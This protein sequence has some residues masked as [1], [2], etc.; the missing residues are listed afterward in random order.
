MKSF[1]VAIAGAGVFGAWTAFFLA[2]AGAKVILIDPHGAGNA[3]SSSGGETRIMRMTYGADE[4]YTRSAIRS[5]AL[6]KQ[7]FPSVFRKTGVLVTSS[8][9]DPYLHGTRETLAR[10]KYRFEWLD[11]AALASRFPSISLQPGSAGIFEPSS[12]VLMARHAVQQVVAAAVDAGARFEIGCVRPDAL[13]KAKTVIFACGPW[14]PSIFPDLLARRIRPTRQP[15]FF[16]GNPE[17]FEVPAW[18]AF[19]EGVYSLPPIDGRGF[20]L[21]IDAH[22]AAF[23]PENG[24][25][26]VSRAEIAKIRA[27]LARRFP[28][29]ADAPLLESRV[30]QYENTSSGDFLIDRHPEIPSVWIA[31]GGS[32]HGFKHGPFVGEYLAA[33]ISGK[34]REEP[35]FLLASKGLSSHRAVF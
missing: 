20:K 30:C 8:A 6:W 34:G 5:L 1:D 25:R 35:R 10:A 17:P 16:F 18:V 7:F 12:G 23:D 31:G 9:A 13:P 11:S 28:A 14:L 26:T 15:V 29:L 22:G 4:I 32:G 19:R 33:R 27:V 3:R 24:Q 21:A 2:R